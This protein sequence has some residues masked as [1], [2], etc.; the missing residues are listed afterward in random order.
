MPRRIATLG[1]E[2]VHARTYFRKAEQLCQA[3]KKASDQSLFDAALILAIHPGISAADAVCIGIGT[4]KNKDSHERAA[5]LL[6]QVGG[7]AREF[8]ISANWLRRLLA[9]KQN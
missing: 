4:R 2:R 5:D 6:E 7:N 1:V 8:E 9:Q 3:A